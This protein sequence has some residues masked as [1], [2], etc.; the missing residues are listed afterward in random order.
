[1]EDVLQSSCYK[2]PLVYDNVDWFADEFIKL[3]NKIAFYF[4]N[5]KKNIVMTDKDEEDYRNNNICRFC[6]KEVLSDKARDDCH[7]TGKY[8]G[9]AQNTCMFNFTQDKSNIIPFIFHNFT[10][11]DCHLLFKK[12]VVKRKVKLISRIYLK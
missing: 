4:K 3:E 7:L 6:E 11:Y 1:M 12:L 8:R 2:S 10:D 5:T 9:P